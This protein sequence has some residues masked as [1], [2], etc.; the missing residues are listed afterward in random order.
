YTDDG[1]PPDQLTYGDATALMEAAKADRQ[2]VMYKISMPG[3]PAHLEV[4]PF[5]AQGRA[6]SA[7]FS[8]TFE[9]LWACAGGWDRE[10][11]TRHGRVVVLDKATNERV[12]GG[13]DS[14]GKTVR[15]QDVDY[16]VTGVLGEWQ[17]RVKF[18]DLTNGTLDRPEAFYIPFTTAI[19][20]QL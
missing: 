4:K 19:E 17:P 1:D 3:Q 6:T 10:Q 16:T 7:A 12:F 18:Y 9:A 13:A 14:V 20:L 5:N 15:L 8:T 2:V 11:D